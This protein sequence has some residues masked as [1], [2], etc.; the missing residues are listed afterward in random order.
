MP[1]GR[2]RPM[3]LFRRSTT[4]SIEARRAAVLAALTEALSP[5]APG[6]DDLSPLLQAFLDAEKSTGF[7]DPDRALASLVPLLPGDGGGRAGRVAMLCGALVEWGADPAP[8]VEPVLAGLRT[9]LLALPEPSDRDADSARDTGGEEPAGDVASQPTDELAAEVLSLWVL[10]AA[11]LLQR[12]PAARHRVREDADLMA[13]LSSPAAEDASWV[14][15]AALLP[16]QERMLVLHPATHRGFWIEVD[17]VADNFQ[18]HTLLAGALIGD[19]ADGLLPGTAPSADLLRIY[20]DPTAPQEA[21][22]AR[23]WF[24]LVNFTGLPDVETAAEGPVRPA[25]YRHW[26]WNE[27]RPADITSFDG[28]RVIVLDEPPYDRSWSGGR[29]FKAVPASV[30]VTGRLTAEEYD[31]WRDRLHGA[32]VDLIAAEPEQI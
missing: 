24:N 1:S 12:S 21:S 22:V 29:M 31:T 25:Q 23:G 20:A 26:I 7:K 32:A 2:I 17:G 13:R 8:A 28:L 18:L 15:D 5:S 14:V 10:P 19:P 30:S 27:G 3:A 6:P 11:A 16:E 4:P 9:A